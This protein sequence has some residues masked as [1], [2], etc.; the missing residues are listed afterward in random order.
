MNAKQKATQTGI[1]FIALLLIGGL[2]LMYKG[3]DALA[4]ATEKKEG[5]L[6][7]EQIK[8]S[9]DSVR[10][11]CLMPGRFQEASLMMRKCHYKFRRLVWSNNS[12]CFK[13]CGLVIMAVL[14][15]PL[16]NSGRPRL[17]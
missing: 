7:A 17:I 16:D 8:M 13:N 15:I 10:C 1:V 3:N 9:F 6:T 12:S 2:I 11:L 14:L 4:L 5:I